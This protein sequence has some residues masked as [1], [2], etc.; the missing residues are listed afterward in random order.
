MIALPRTVP[1]EWV[2]NVRIPSVG[3]I[4][5]LR[6]STEDQISQQFFSSTKLK[7]EGKTN[8]RKKYFKNGEQHV[9]DV[10]YDVFHY[11][12]DQL[13]RKGIHP[14]CYVA[15]NGWV[16]TDIYISLEQGFPTCGTR[17]T[18]GTRRCPRWYAKSQKFW[19]LT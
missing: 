6:C 10:V 1:W 18:S 19:F 14:R 2:F 9:N 3:K 4:V 8:F 7:L 13:S 16:Q 17:T 12:L 11:R 15:W 5:F